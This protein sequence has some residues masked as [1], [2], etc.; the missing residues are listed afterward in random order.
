[1]ST[2][3]ASP[4]D[5]GRRF[6]ITLA[7]VAIAVALAV[8]A[9]FWV[10]ALFFASKDA[11]NRFDDRDWTARAEGLC[12]A[13]NVEREA[14]AD[15]R[16]I[17]PADPALLAERA[18]TIDRATDLLERMLDEVTAI[19]PTDPKGRA[20]VPLWEADYRTYL[21]NR[22]DFAD[23]V[24]TGS[25]DVLRVAMTDGVP[26]TEPLRVFA[27]DNDMASCAPPRDL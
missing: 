4:P 19:E 14:L 25:N 12:A 5:A 2:P 26:I 1:M 15:F 16:R 17:D 10:W 9:T 27:A 21:Q 13:A 18:D 22:R 23:E 20:I 24:R 7:G 6:R 3:V 11:I 8:F